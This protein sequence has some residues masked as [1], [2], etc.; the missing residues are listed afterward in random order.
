MQHLTATRATGLFI[1]AL[2]FLFTLTT[3]GQASAKDASLKSLMTQNSITMKIVKLDREDG[4]RYG[5]SMKN[6]N[7]TVLIARG[8]DRMMLVQ[9]DGVEAVLQPDAT[10]T[11]QVI[12]AD[13]VDISLVLCYAKAVIGFLESLTICPQDDGV[14]FIL[15]FVT[16]FQDVADCNNVVTQ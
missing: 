16:L 2:V 5:L 15:A 9:A 7:R 8:Y 10:G 3:V 4:F 1:S 13:D 12:Q 11:L 14:C 6:Q